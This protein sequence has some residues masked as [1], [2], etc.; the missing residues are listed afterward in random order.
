MFVQS[1]PTGPKGYYTSVVGQPGVIL[2]KVGFIDRIRRALGGSPADHVG[3]HAAPIGAS[4]DY[5]PQ[6]DL[7]RDTAR[8]LCADAWVAN[9][10]T[11]SISSEG[12]MQKLSV[13]PEGVPYLKAAYSIRRE[14]L[15]PEMRKLVDGL[16]G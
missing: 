5:G 3:G 11:L 16:A 1:R 4:S 8:D 6:L 7:L 13:I 14:Q 10:L 2:A 15:A 9:R 12:G